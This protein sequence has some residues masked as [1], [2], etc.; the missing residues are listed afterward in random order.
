MGQ[1]LFSRAKKSNGV[2]QL[3]VELKRSFVPPLGMNRE[4]NRFM[5]RLEYMDS[6]TI[7]F[8][9]GGVENPQQLFSK[10]RLFPGRVSNLTKK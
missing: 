9:Q 1:Q 4:Y 10:F 6:Q 8:S 2:R 7:L 5:E 3:R